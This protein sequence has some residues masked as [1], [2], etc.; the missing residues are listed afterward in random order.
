V[1]KKNAAV[2][3]K[4]VKQVKQAPKGGTLDGLRRASA[5][6]KQIQ[7]WMER[8]W[9][10]A[11]NAGEWLRFAAALKAEGAVIEAAAL[12]HVNPS[13]LVK[14]KKELIQ[15]RARAGKEEPAAEGTDE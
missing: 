2:V 9:P 8:K 4:Q 14:S 15:E 3:K 13:L 6:R 5:V 7:R 12:E 10:L 1:A 11:S